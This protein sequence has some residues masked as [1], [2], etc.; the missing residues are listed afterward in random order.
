MLDEYSSK[1]AYSRKNIHPVFPEIVN[2][3][4]IYPFLLDFYVSVVYNNVENKFERT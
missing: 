2:K 1:Y 4:L 3:F